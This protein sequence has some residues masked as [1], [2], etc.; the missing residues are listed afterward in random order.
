M[1]F[2]GSYDLDGSPT[3][4]VARDFNADG[5]ID[6]ATANAGSDTVNL[7]F[8]QHGDNGWAGF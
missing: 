5:L 6:L 4:I 8:G 2:H 7:L 1:T 3:S